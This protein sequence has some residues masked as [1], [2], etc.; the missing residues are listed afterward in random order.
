MRIQVWSYR[1]E[2]Y[3]YMLK[4]SSLMLKYKTYTIKSLEDALVA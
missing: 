4:D 3:L 1:N 2:E